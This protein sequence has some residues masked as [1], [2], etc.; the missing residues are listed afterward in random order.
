MEQH[1]HYLDM[2]N[3]DQYCHHLMG[4][5][6]TDLVAYTRLVPAGVTFPDAAIGRV[7]IAAAGRRQGVGT[8]LMEQSLKEVLRLYGAVPVRLG[9]QRHLKAFYEVF[10]FEQTSA[11]YM[12]AGIEH[13]QMTR[14]ARLW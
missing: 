4:L 12:D 13:I 8:L 14:P 6:G 9:A 2:D 7:V 1:C 5:T 10:G 11:V 3:N